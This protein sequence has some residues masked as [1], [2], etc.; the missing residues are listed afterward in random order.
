LKLAIAGNLHEPAVLEQQTRRML[1]DP[2]ARALV[3]NFA[4]Q[5][6]YLRD[7]KSAK[8]DDGLFPDFDETCV[9]HSARDELLSTA[10]Q[11][12]LGARSAR[13]RLHVHNASAK[14]YGIPNVAVPTS[15]SGRERRASRAAGARCFLL[16]TPSPNRPGDSR[17]VDLEICSAALRRSRLQTPASKKRRRD[18]ET[19]RNASNCTKRTDPRR[20]QGMD[21]IGLSLENFDAIGRWRANDEGVAIDASSQLVDGT[22]MSGPASLRKA[23]L[24]RSEALVASLTEKLLMYGVGRETTYADMTVVRAITH[25][26][27]PQRYRLSDLILGVVSSRPFQWR[28]DDVNAGNSSRKAE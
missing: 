9:R 18:R 23:L 2:K 10:S 13:C 22:A 21:P 25:G 19:V 12:P 16:V 26:A 17:Q 15:A 24:D 27:A 5:W 28:V 20:P 7:L 14:H 8:P 4:A 11:K 1:A 3:S 6:L